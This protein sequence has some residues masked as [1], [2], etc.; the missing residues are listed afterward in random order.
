MKHHMKSFILFFTLVS[1]FFATSCIAYAAPEY[2]AIEPNAVSRISIAVERTTS[3]NAVIRVTGSATSNASSITMTATLYEYISGNLI[4][5]DATPVT[6]TIN[7]SMTFDFDFNFRLESNKTY[8][9][10]V[11]VKDVTNGVTTTTNKTSNS[12]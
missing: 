9:V 8:K 4:K 1:I 5:A 3:T 10:K 7:N 11:V 6:Q 2:G 12:F